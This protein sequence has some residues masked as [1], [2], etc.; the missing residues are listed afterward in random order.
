MVKKEPIKYPK[1]LQL[2]VYDF[3]DSTGNPY[4]IQLDGTFTSS[5]GKTYIY[6]KSNTFIDKA[7]SFLYTPDQTVV[8]T[9]KNGVSFNCLPRQNRSHLEDPIEKN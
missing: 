2:P 5:S 9:D 1:F 8:F 3:I 7:T 4:D 6:T